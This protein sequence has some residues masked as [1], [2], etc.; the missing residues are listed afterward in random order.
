MND[1][2][3][4]TNLALLAAG[5]LATFFVAFLAVYALPLAD[6]AISTPT[7]QTVEYTE[8]ALRG[9]SVYDR[10][11]C[12]FCH[13]Q[14]VRPVPSDVGLGP[15]TA[16]DRYARD[17]RATIGLARIGPDLACVGDRLDD[18]EE[19]SAHLAD[20]RE[21]RPRSVM[22]NYDYLDSEEMS[23]LTSYLTALVCG[24]DS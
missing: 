11:G 5:T 2:S 3:P 14:Q 20:P 22:P 17:P 24:G 10:E 13:T 19:L 18:A 16:A 15:M 1:E 21:S 8:E 6:P 9:K 12:W 4:G 23:A 7:E